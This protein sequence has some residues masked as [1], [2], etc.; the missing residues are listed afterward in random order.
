M[1]NFLLHVD[2]CDFEEDEQGGSSGQSGQTADCDADLT[3]S[4]SG[5]KKREEV[6]ALALAFRE[7]R[8]E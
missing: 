5:K 3:A 2:E 1:H 8:N 6:L 4:A 7:K